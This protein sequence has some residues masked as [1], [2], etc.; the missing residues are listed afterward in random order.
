MSSASAGPSSK[1]QQ[2]ANSAPRPHSHLASAP[3]PHLPEEGREEYLRLDMNE[4]L[5][6]PLIRTAMPRGAH[7]AMYPTTHELQR[8]LSAHLRRPES[9]IRV[10]AGADEGIYG[11]I[12]A[13]AGVGDAVLLPWPT[14]VEFPTASAAVGARIVPAPYGADL[15]FP[16]DLYRQELL[17]GP[18]VAAIVTPAN[19]T[20]DAL[21]PQVVTAFAACAPG[22]LL[23]VDEAYYEYGGRSVLDQGPLPTNVAVI[24]TFSKAYG[25]AAARVGY[26]VAHPEVQRALRQVLPSYSLAGPSLALA[27]SALARQ[28]RLAR[29]V[30][31]VRKG[32][33]RIA[34]WG[35]RYGISVHTTEANFV[36]LRLGD[37]AR[38]QALAA[39]LEQQGILVADRTHVLPGTLRVTVG[40]P[41]HVDRFLAG[42]Q[43]AL[44]AL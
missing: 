21:E 31:A 5:S 44:T 14:F 13:Y 29:R 17:Q 28:D 8:A 37:D 11:L 41:R 24:R 30:A 19:P 3:A 6:G 25:L 4:D 36:L 10:T 22:T 39:A 18:R 43:R 9:M 33:L 12:R 40:A 26:V 20:G 7:L 35:R 27:I 15:R 16:I 34:A 23:I 2:P 38:A 42:M 1:Q 32:R